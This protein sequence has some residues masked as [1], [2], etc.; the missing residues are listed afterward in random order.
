MT[1]VLV[2][3]VVLAL[4][5]PASA[6]IATRYATSTARG[7][8]STGACLTT[9]TRCTVAYAISLSSAGDTVSLESNTINN[10]Y[11]YQNANDVIAPPTGLS[12]VTVKAEVDGGVII[13]GQFT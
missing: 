10:P 4:T 1:R 7:G 2:L 5:T 9:A 11:V 8:L 6:A 13:D 12:G 3:L